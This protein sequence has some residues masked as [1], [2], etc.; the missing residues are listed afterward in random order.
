MVSGHWSCDNDP[1]SSLP[2][3]EVV[4]APEDRRYELHLDGQRVGLADYWVD[5]DVMTIPHVETDPA[6]RGKDFAARLMA[7][8]LDEARARRLTIRPVC[9]YAALYMQRRPETHDLIAS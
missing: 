4:H 6:H 9:S 7:G 3:F 8:V 2:S 1:M 5:G